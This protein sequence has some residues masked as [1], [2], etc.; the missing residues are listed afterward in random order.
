MGRHT[1][2]KKSN[3]IQFRILRLGRDVSWIL[4]WAASVEDFCDEDVC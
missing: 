4:L 3:A 1:V 2:L